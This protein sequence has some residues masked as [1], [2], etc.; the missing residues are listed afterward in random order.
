MQPDPRPVPA[1]GWCS[2]CEGIETATHL[3]ARFGTCPRC[4]P[5]AAAWVLSDPRAG[6]N[7]SV[8]QEPLPR[9]AVHATKHGDCHE[10][11][12]SDAAA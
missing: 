1:G 6:R 7:C 4:K 9:T 11:G 3:P 10:R 5:I 8:C 2:D 12:V